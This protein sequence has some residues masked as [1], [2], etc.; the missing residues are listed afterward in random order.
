MDFSDTA[1]SHQGDAGI[2]SIRRVG[3][4]YDPF[5]TSSLTLFD[6]HYYKGSSFYTIDSIAYMQDFNDKA[7]SLIVTGKE[8]WTI[9]A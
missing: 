9:Y 5:S 8:S 6:G 4:P 3:E 1:R 2:S 7:S